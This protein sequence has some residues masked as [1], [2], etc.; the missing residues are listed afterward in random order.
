[1]DKKGEKPEGKDE[2]LVCNFQLLLMLLEV[3]WSWDEYLMYGLE[4]RVSWK[5]VFED[6]LMNTLDYLSVSIILTNFCWF[7]NT[8]SKTQ[9]QLKLS[10][11]Q[12]ISLNI[13]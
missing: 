2:L 3:F 5:I 11:K 4:E 12:T 9:T 10:Y 8:F 7:K 6:L 1:M 13:V